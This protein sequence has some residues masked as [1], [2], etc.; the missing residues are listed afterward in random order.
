MQ[1]QTHTH[2]HTQHTD[3]TDYKSTSRH[4]AYETQG[5]S[6]HRLNCAS[7]VIVSLIIVMSACSCDRGLCDLDSCIQHVVSVI[8]TAGRT[9]SRPTL[10]AETCISI[11]QSEENQLVQ[12]CLLAVKIILH[13]H[14][15]NVLSLKLTGK[16]EST[17]IPEDT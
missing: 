15:D 3:K 10:Q 12:A 6:M 5:I 2:T 7:S 13:L 8:L 14:H 9:S 17:C 4:I 11:S 1:V 16:Y